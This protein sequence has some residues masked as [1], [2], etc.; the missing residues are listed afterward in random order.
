MLPPLSAISLS[1]KSVVASLEV[2]VNTIDAS[3]DVSPPLTVE[4]VIAIVGPVESIT[5]VG[6]VSDFALPVESVTMTVSPV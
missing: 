6:I 2:K 1:S 5:K 3:F 4:L